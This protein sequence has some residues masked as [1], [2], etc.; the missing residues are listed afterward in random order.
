[1]VWAAHWQISST[2]SYHNVP[3]L[4]LWHLFII[5]V[6]FIVLFPSPPQFIFQLS[7]STGRKEPPLTLGHL[8]STPTRGAEPVMN[9]FSTSLTPP[10][11]I[12]NRTTHGSS[13]GTCA[14][15][16][17]SSRIPPR[18]QPQTLL[19]LEN[20]TVQRSRLAQ[21]GQLRLRANYPDDF[22][23]RMA[24]PVALPKAL[25]V[26]MPWE[27]TQLHPDPVPWHSSK[28]AQSLPVFQRCFN[29]LNTVVPPAQ[30]QSKM[31][32]VIWRGRQR[33]RN[34]TTTWAVCREGDKNPHFKVTNS[35]FTNLTENWRA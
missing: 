16:W 20:P 15:A 25:P 11:E 33:R 7:C 4:V 26:P 19:L 22:C 2:S 29:C 3:I 23:E 12:I 21:L 1:M 9:A 27:I 30:E 31:Q 32:D 14:L 18:C 13:V 10:P 28:P 5:Q 34:R 24:E 35:S 6:H 17:R 8:P